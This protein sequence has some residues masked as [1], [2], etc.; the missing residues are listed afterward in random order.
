[1]ISFANS[2]KVWSFSP[3]DEEFFDEFRSE[4]PVSLPDQGMGEYQE[5]SSYQESASMPN[6]IAGSEHEDEDVSM[7][8]APDEEDEQDG[9]ATPEAEL[10]DEAEETSN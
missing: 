6:L 1:M 4:S 10:S 5:G 7:S 8:D 3:P 9:R 2:L